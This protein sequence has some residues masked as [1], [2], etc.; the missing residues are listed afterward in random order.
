MS[1]RPAIL[2]ALLRPRIV[3]ADERRL[4]C[5]VCRRA[6]AVHMDEGRPAAVCN[7]CRRRHGTSTRLVSLAQ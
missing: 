1:V 4:T 5:D 2:E 3:A 6:P 7:R